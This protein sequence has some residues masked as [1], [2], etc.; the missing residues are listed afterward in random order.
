MRHFVIA[1]LV[2][3]TYWENISLNSYSKIHGSRQ[4]MRSNLSSVTA[5]LPRLETNRARA[6]QR[7]WYRFYFFEINRKRAT[8]NSAMFLLIHW[9][10]HRGFDCGKMI[11]F[12]F[13]IFGDVYTRDGN[14]SLC[15]C[16]ASAQIVVSYNWLTQVLG[17]IPFTPSSVTKWHDRHRYLLIYPV[18][19]LMSLT[20]HRPCSKT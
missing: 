12:T 9:Y 4:P 15:Q 8:R 6:G 19:Y 3:H 20:S 7:L 5:A 18:T 1:C 2:C 14:I 17:S 13:K 10:C 16:D 11:T